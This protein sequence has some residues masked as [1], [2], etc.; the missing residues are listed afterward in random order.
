MNFKVD[1][2]FNITFINESGAD[3]LGYTPQALIGQPVFGTLMEDRVAQRE[4]LSATLS[5]MC[6]HQSTINTRTV[7][8][9][10]NQQK[11]LIQILQ[12]SLRLL[13][14][15]QLFCLMLLLSFFHLLEKIQKPLFIQDKKRSNF[16][17]NLGRKLSIMC[18][19]CLP[20]LILVLFY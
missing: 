7:L 17:L 12:I 4:A 3:I 5:K 13:E 9:K 15:V 6:K 11:Q 10:H 16:G 14:F 1:K 2:D 20:R 18:T 19:Y 8:L